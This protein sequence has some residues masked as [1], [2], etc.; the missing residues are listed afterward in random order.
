MSTAIGEEKGDTEEDRYKENRYTSDS[1]DNREDNHIGAD[2]RYQNHIESVR[3]EWDAHLSRYVSP[4]DAVARWGGVE[5]LRK[6]VLMVKRYLSLNESSAGRLLDA[7]CGAGAFIYELKKIS[8]RLQ[9]F[10]CDIS[11]EMVRKASLL[12]SGVNSGFNQHSEASKKSSVPAFCASDIGHLPYRDL[13]FDYLVCYS[14][15]H[16]LPSMEYL[17][18]T[19]KEFSRITKPGGR[20]VLGDV[21]SADKMWR[22]DYFI[23]EKR[24][25]LE[26]EG[27]TYDS[28]TPVFCPEK[29]LWIDE[30]KIVELLRKYHLKPRVVE[31]E[32][33]CQWGSPCDGDRYD[34][35]AV[36]I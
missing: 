23:P 1:S 17:E 2:E 24:K 31:Q 30:K 7:G 36:K 14:V 19:V 33:N 26:E 32:E 34:I 28:S 5:E 10:G 21:L 18:L 25:K 9:Y 22:C 29:W 35:V 8:P 12:F 11:R 13:A 4:V 3:R 20:I 16:Y 15:L 27:Y 6:V